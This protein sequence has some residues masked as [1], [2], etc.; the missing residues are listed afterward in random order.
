MQLKWDAIHS[1]SSDCGFILGKGQKWNVGTQKIYSN[2]SCWNWQGNC[3]LVNCLSNR[4][5]FYNIGTLSTFYLCIMPARSLYCKL[6]H[7]KGVIYWKW[8]IP[9]C[10]CTTKC[11]Y[12]DWS[13]RLT[14]HWF[15]YLIERMEYMLVKESFVVDLYIFWESYT[16]YYDSLNIKRSWKVQKLNSGDVKIWF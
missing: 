16:I 10:W 13:R 1:K 7:F 12:I 14:R 4:L 11:F 5:S 3:I 2:D 6:L 15:W 8:I 9:L